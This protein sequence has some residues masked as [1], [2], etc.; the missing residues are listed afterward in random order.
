MNCLTLCVCINFHLISLYDC[1]K[2]LPT[3]ISRARWMPAWEKM[4]KFQEEHESKFA[5]LSASPTGFLWELPTQL[6]T[7]KNKTKTHTQPALAALCCTESLGSNSSGEFHLAA[8][9]HC[10]VAVVL[11]VWVIKTFPHSCSAICDSL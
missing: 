2:W 5:F 3:K 1:T 10:L 6:D 7:G 9:R 11:C 8:G 4:S